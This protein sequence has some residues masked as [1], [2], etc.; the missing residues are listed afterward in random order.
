MWMAC[1]Q[2]IVLRLC[3]H[4]SCS[5]VI[6]E[7]MIHPD[8]G[9]GNAWN[10]WN[11]HNEVSNMHVGQIAITELYSSVYIAIHVPST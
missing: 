5:E 7:A 10:L 3:S 4:Q 6:S 1:A 2:S 9:L 11:V 8:C